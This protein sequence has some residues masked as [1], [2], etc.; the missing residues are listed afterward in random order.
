VQREHFAAAAVDQE[1]LGV[2]AGGEVDLHQAAVETLRQRIDLERL[3]KAALGLV[4][5]LRARVRAA[6]GFQET[7]QFSAQAFTRGQDP[8]VFDVILKKGAPLKRH[9]LV[10]EFG[11]FVRIL[12]AA[13]ALQ[14]RQLSLKQPDIHPAAARVEG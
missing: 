14:C 2:P 8:G 3:L 11:A 10:G 6:H 12:A 5:A 13:G 9:E 1:G 4:V 7:Q